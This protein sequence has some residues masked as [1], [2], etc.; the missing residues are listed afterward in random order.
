MRLLAA[1]LPAL[2]LAVV[3][4]WL[5]ATPNLAVAHGGWDLVT[6]KTAHFLVFAALALACLRGATDHGL[7][8][9]AAASVA[10]AL[11]VAYAI[12]DELHQTTVAGRHGSPIDV[13]IDTLGAIVGLL[14]VGRVPRLARVVLLPTATAGAAR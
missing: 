8:R 12:S 2:V 7:R 3:I 13:G 1:W 10:L 9:R 6:R 5:S 11:T 4:F 14:L